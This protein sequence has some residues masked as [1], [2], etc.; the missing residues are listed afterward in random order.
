MVKFNDEG[1]LQR[2]RIRGRMKRGK[3]GFAG[4]WLV[5]H[6]TK[7]TGYIQFKSNY[8]A[9]RFSCPEKYIGK[10]VKIKLIVCDE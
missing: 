1:Y 4:I 2:I 7:S 5:K 3:S 6:A 8:T 9:L 10:R